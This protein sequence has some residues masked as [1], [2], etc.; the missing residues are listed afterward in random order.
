M[1][2]RLARLWVEHCAACGINSAPIVE[3]GIFL[4]M[5]LL[6]GY[7]HMCGT[8][9]CCDRHV[10]DSCSQGLLTKHEAAYGRERL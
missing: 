4:A 3:Y 5:G 2:P 8:L 6:C 9:F 1:G 10:C 7:R